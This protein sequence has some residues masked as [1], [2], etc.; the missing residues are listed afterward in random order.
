METENSIQSHLLQ[1]IERCRVE[2]QQVHQAWPTV[3]IDS[4][5]V[6]PCT[7]QGSDGEAVIWTPVK[8]PLNDSF[9]KVESAMSVTLHDAAKQ[10]WT[11]VFSENIA[12]QYD[13]LE[14]ELLLPWNQDDFERFQENLVGH[15]LTQRRFKLEP[16]V[17]IGLV[18]DSEVMVAI[19][20]DGQ[21]VLEIPGRKAHRTL[22]TDFLSFIEQ[23]SPYSQA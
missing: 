15:L 1:F 4:D 6:S 20:D 23:S 22:A 16:T 21:V 9:D 10:Y 13:D 7:P 3:E 5:W 19:D 8:R 17:F 18:I 2:Y 11:S 12:L 14:I